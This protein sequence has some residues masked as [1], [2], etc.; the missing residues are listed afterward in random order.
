MGPEETMT[1]KLG[2]TVWGALITVYIFWGS[3]YLAIGYVVDS[4]PPFIGAAARFV[5]AGAIMAVI[6]LFLRGRGGMRMRWREA[7]TAAL[8]GVLLLCGGNGVV[9][10]GEQRVPTG[11]AA[12]LIASVPLWIVVLRA[13]LGDR[14]RLATV[15]GIVLGLVGVGLL[16]L[17]GGGAGDFSRGHALLIVAAAISWSVGS[18]LVT[19]WP[20]PRNPLALTAVEMLAGGVA[21]LVCAVPLGE[22]SGFSLGQVQA[23]AWIATGYLIVFGSLVA[24]TAYVYILGAAPVSLVSTYAYVNP[25][26]AVLLGVLFR[27]ER[28]GAS[29][30]V[31]ALVIV[32]AVAVVVTEE[33][34]SRARAA[35]AAAQPLP[36]AA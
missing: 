13:V 24:F 2:L 8:A 34:R 33:G 21:L 15:L 32:A 18:V 3:T 20:V 7:G 12:L 14:P 22:W 17:P 11:L 10:I 4:A 26:I 25:V 35:K 27:H 31:G 29:T 6:V 28:L 5:T 16:L 36:E 1:Q 19:R 9:A 30:V 23:G